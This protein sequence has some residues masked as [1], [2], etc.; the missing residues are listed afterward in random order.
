MV[1]GM[2]APQMVAETHLDTEFAFL[3]LGQSLPPLAMDVL[4][5][6]PSKPSQVD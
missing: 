5:L 6:I 1:V 4:L 3:D 2:T